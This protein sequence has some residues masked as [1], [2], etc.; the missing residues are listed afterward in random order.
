MSKTGFQAF[1]AGMIVATSVLGITYFFSEN[2]SAAADAKKTET[3]ASEVESYLTDNGKISISTEEYEEL[4]ASKDAAV[5]QSAQ[6]EQNQETAVKEEKPKTE[7]PAKEKEEQAITYKLNV[8]AGMTT[9]E[10]SNMLEQNGIISDSF[11]FDQF[12]IKN[13]YHQ[14]VQLGTFD[15]KKG[16]SFQQL[17]E[18][19]TN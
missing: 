6:T 17:A 18:V 14:K 15:V 19:L 1:A 5:Q 9:N 12:L 10:I 7:E 11:E 13:G 4:L 3:T 8:S 2:Q 16:M